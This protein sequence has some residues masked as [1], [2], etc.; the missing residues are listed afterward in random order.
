MFIFSCLVP[1][2]PDVVVVHAARSK[3]SVPFLSELHRQ[4][5]T[6][7]N[8]AAA[9]AATGGLVSQDEEA[10]P[11]PNASDGSSRVRFV[12]ATTRASG[13][14]GGGGEGG[15]GGGARAN[16]SPCFSAVEGRPDA[17]MLEREVPDVSERHVF[18][19]GPGVFMVAMEEALRGLGVPSSR[20]HSEEFYF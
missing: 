4:P 9:A 6:T 12:L 13:G 5:A 2:H 18:L 14:R 19:C 7:T 1:G 17:A 10:P 15:G 8:A 20:I 3:D 11:S 16:S